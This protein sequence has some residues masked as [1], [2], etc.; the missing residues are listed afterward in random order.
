MNTV[1]VQDARFQQLVFDYDNTVLRA[2]QE[3]EDALV[4]Y[5]RGQEQ[6]RILSE[7]VRAA[8][9]A[10]EIANIQYES[11]GADY[12]RVLNSE[13]A[14][15]R[16]D[17]LLIATRGT[18]AFSVIA[19]YKAFGGGWEIGGGKDFVSEETKREMR[20]RVN[21][22]DLLTSEG[23]ASDLK[24]ATDGTEQERGWWRWRWWG[25]KW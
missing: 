22:G 6:V 19:L 2:Q 20:T 7:S 11:G 13:Q 21:W 8:A 15:T 14:K 12:T 9:R 1:R 3:V 4:V 24:A 17:D 16:E 10:V 25:P 23:Q 5:L 18:V